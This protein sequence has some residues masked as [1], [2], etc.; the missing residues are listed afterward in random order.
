MTID[1]QHSSLTLE[2]IPGLREFRQLLERVWGEELVSLVLF[3]SQARG[4]AGPTSDIDLLIIK[5]GLPRSRFDRTLMVFHLAQTVSEDFAYRL[6]KVLLTPEE[7]EETK[8]YYLDMTEEA[9]ILFDRGDF[10]K[11]V[12]DRLRQ[13]MRELGSRRVR[14]SDGNP[15][16]ILKPDA[17]PGEAIIL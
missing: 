15:Y 7:A 17:K 3:G 14:D 9:V 5:K 6:S 4:E 10:F 12:M 16:W 1:S 2:A 8:P 11:G 13:R